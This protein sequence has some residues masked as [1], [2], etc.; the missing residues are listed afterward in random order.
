MVD[1]L[2]SGIRTVWISL[3][4]KGP[5]GKDRMLRVVCNPRRDHLPLR[6]LKQGVSCGTVGSA[7]KIRA[8]E[9]VAFGSFFFFFCSFLEALFAAFDKCHR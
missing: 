1:A 5:G 6:M 2:S 7:H 3:L 8:N 9:N 4:N